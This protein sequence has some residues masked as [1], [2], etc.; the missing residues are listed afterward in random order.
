MKF[1]WSILTAVFLL[2]A[3]LLCGCSSEILRNQTIPIRFDELL[4][5]L[6]NTNFTEQL[7]NQTGDSR[8]A[9]SRIP[10]EHHM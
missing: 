5:V 6:N 3:A 9:C 7:T 2:S 10:P 4:S 8:L 1:K